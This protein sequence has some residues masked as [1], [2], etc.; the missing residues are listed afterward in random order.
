MLGKT[1]L[2]MTFVEAFGLVSNLRF[3]IPSQSEIQ[4]SSASVV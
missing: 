3:F 1:N 4:T 2:G